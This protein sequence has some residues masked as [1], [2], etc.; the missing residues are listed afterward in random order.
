[1]LDQLE[2]GG[3]GAQNSSSTIEAPIAPDE[4]GHAV[5][6]PSGDFEAGSWQT[7]QLVYT[8][9]KYGMDDSASMRVCFR[10]A[11]D[12]SRT[13][14]VATC[15]RRSASVLGSAARTATCRRR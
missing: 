4:L 2:E 15:Y 7:F 9:G 11:S 6:T 8:C 10:F 5:L 12:Q 1:M 14:F 13:I 3:Q